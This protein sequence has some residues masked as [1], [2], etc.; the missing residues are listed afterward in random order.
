M[1]GGIVNAHLAR[2]GAKLGPDPASI[3]ACMIGGIVANNSSGM[4]CG[5]EHNA[6]R[7]LES[8]RFVLPSR[9]GD[10]HR[11][12]GRRRVVR[13]E[14]AGDRARPHGAADRASKASRG[15][16]TRIRAKYRMKNTMGY[17]L[18]AFLD[19]DT[20]LSILWHLLVG[21]EG[22]LAFIAEAVF[23]TIPDLPLKSTG[24]SCSPSVPAACEAIEPLRASGAKALELM[25]RGV[26]ALDRGP[27]RASRAFVSELPPQAA[28]ILAEYQAETDAELADSEAAFREAAP[29][30]PPDGAAAVHARRDV[31]G[32]PV[33]RAQGVDRHDRRD[34]PARA[35]H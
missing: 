14:G 24:L 9:H 32:P 27:A 33:G 23:R 16:W 2:H 34:A 4:C 8:L 18:N 28:A 1:V 7:T 26:A 13:G 15:S 20:P 29:A 19:F 22:T 5:I 6:Y 21:S 3:G 12:A 25:D 35:R 17:A 31:A 11:G 10:R 30:A